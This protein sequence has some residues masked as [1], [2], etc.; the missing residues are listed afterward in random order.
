MELLSPAG[1]FDALIAAAQNGANAVYFGGG[2]FNAR[3]FAD[4]F[5]PEEMK[6][7]LD[8]CHARGVAAHV[9]LNIL[10]RDRE[11][12]RAL[13]YAASLYEMGVDALIVQDLGL[14]R[15]LKRELPDFELHASTQM[16]I[17]DLA[18]VEMTKKLGF[19][20]AVLSREVPLREIAYIHKHTDQPLE[21]FAHGAM[22]VSFSGGCLMSSMAGER[23]G[24]R[25][26]CAQ[27][28]RKPYSLKGKEGYLLSM[29]DLCM[30][31]R[32][33]EMKKA[34]IMSLKLEGRMKRPEYVAAVTHAY[35][36]AI[37]GADAKT[38]KQERERIRQVF[39]RGG[40]HCGYYDGRKT[41]ITGCRA[42]QSPSA[43]L[44]KELRASFEGE[45]RRRPVDML[46]TLAV[47]EAAQLCISLGDTVLTVSGEAAAEAQK[48]QDPA[49][50]AAQL[51]KLGDTPF[52]AGDI[53]V[54]M[55]ENAFL[56]ASVLNALRR[57][58]VEALL[59]ALT[60][61]RETLEA[62][63]EPLP[64]EAEDAEP[65]VSVR[66]RTLEQAKAAVDAGAEELIFEPI[67]YSDIPKDALK[68]LAPKGGLYLSLPAVMLTHVDQTHMKRLLEEDVFDGAEI[69][70]LGQF[71]LVPEGKKCLAGAELNAMNAHTV[72]HYRE[73][74][75]HRVTLSREL[76]KPQ[77]RDIIKK[78]GCGVEIYNRVPVMELLHC[79]VRQNY[80]CQNCKGYVE[81]LTDEA[82]RKFP[83][84]NIRQSD[85]CLVRLLNC[86]VTDIIAQSAEL[87]APL[88]WNLAFDL[89]SPE[90]VALRVKAAIAA[91]AG[92]RTEPAA[93]ST[94]GHWNRA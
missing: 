2:E 5:G 20:R 64:E 33:E 3:R 25:G 36:M 10:L 24:N 32:I 6:R 47:G 68:A 42:E 89:E 50:Y 18:G 12:P 9:T 30:L 65:L 8:Y 37:D 22:C 70:A 38:L 28:C 73:L 43:A 87:P 59:T 76:T 31:E 71:P 69:H 16:G 21:C 85:G 48:P 11:L 39:D 1:S 34:G 90:E 74:G 49:R 15:E 29:A 78:G 17:H 14:A 4:N 60:A 35:R 51:A 93:N 41:F 88:A 58:A 56:P 83:M 27:P 77:L 91:R 75:A 86:D 66:A 94:R 84:T 81:T 72:K 13:D 44:L 92:E 62:K 46:L 67:D 26:T 55:P 80:G 23:S 79:P 53:R 82:G 19:A 61:G 63:V 7:A 40:F 52:S 57:D 54:E 45:N